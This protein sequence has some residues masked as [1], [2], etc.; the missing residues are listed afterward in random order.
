MHVPRLLRSD[1][2]SR[3]DASRVVLSAMHGAVMHRK[4]FLEEQ[5]ALKGSLARS[6]AMMENDLDA[7]EEDLVEVRGHIAAIDARIDR[8]RSG[9]A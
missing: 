4:D 7:T 3:F 1:L 2:L 9:K 5:L 8:L 6:A